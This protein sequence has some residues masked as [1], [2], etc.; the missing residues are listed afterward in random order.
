MFWSVLFLHGYFYEMRC[1]IPGVPIASEFISFWLVKGKEMDLKATARK[2]EPVDV[3]PLLDNSP[4]AE[5]ERA[6]EDLELV[7]YIAS[8]DLEAPLRTMMRVCE[9]LKGNRDIAAN[10]DAR[11][12]LQK[13]S[14]ETARM[15]LLMQGL[16]EY[17]RLVT[18]APSYADLDMN[19]I[20]AAAISA[21]QE[22]IH[23]AKAEISYG[24][25]PLVRGHRGR[26]T[27]LFVN[28]ID[29]ASKFNTHEH[30]EIR[31]T[32]TVPIDGYACFCV[33][34]NGIGVDDEYHNIIFTLYQ[35]L[36]TEA[37]YP[38]YGI[39]LAL[40]KKIVESHGGRIW[41]ESAVGE[42]SRFRFLLPVVASK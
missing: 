38:G 1:Y 21:Q 5:L 14:D 4:A 29:N 7:S 2:S 41:V 32:T 40:C 30:P 8:H 34:D 3:R 13:I 28:L 42:G 9:E 19:E 18:Y 39:G 37:E 26:L 23:T 20:I 33:S 10:D 24:G 22:K 6:R 15:K 36:H 11:N 27:R 12:G 35:R 16:L 17:M 25:L 31:I